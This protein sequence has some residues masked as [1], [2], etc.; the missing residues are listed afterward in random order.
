MQLNLDYPLLIQGK[1]I[2]HYQY[3]CII[4]TL[5]TCSN[6]T[7]FTDLPDKYYA[8][9][10]Q[11]KTSLSQ[12]SSSTHITTTE[13]LVPG[14]NGPLVVMKMKGNTIPRHI[15]ERI[16]TSKHLPQTRESECHTPCPSDEQYSVQ[17]ISIN[18]SHDAGSGSVTGSEEKYPRRANQ[19]SRRRKKSP[20]SS[21]P[22][23]VAIKT[24]SMKMSSIERRGEAY[25]F[26]SGVLEEKSSY[27]EVTSQS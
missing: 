10:E 9:D 7:Y 4:I 14:D 5:S 23:R 20:S 13:S 26:A 24:I 21:M 16:Q 17:N 18:L 1:G 11:V 19:K 25:A 27:L 6:Y 3:S 8:T 2:S 12:T 22:T 15:K